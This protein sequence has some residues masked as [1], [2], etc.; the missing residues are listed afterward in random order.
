MRRVPAILRAWVV[1]SLVYLAAMAMWSYD[2]L[3]SLLFQ[4][5]VAAF[6]SAVFVGAA[7]LA[8]LILRVPPIGR[9][10][11]SDTSCAGILCVASLGVMCFGSSLGLTSGY[12]DPE[13]GHRFAALHPAAA[14]A[15]Y[16][17]LLFAITHWP[18]STHQEG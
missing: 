1:G 4:P 2:G 14:L 16:L 8:G 7:L 6:V 12:V 10:W 11:G 9:V 13:S 5:F 18:V 15:S 3:V 17:L